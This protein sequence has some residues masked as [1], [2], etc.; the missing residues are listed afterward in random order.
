MKK[1]SCKR[2]RLERTIFR[3]ALMM[4]VLDVFLIAGYQGFYQ[5][6]ETAP[7]VRAAR[8]AESRVLAH[9]AHGVLQKPLVVEDLPQPQA[10][11]SVP[12][13]EPESP[14]SVI[15]EKLLKPALGHFNGLAVPELRR[16]RPARVVV[17]IDDMGLDPRRN[18]MAM[19][20]PGPLTL[21]FL[22]YGKNLQRA[23]A[24]AKRRGHEVLVHMPMEPLDAALDPGPE[25][26]RADMSKGLL[27]QALLDNL[28]A[29]SGYVGINNHMGSRLTQDRRA[30]G[31]VMEILQARG[32]LFVDSRTIENSVAEDMAAQYNVDHATRDVFLDHVETPEAV[33]QS[34]RKLED[35]AYRRGYA[36]AIG[37]PK[38][39]T[40]NA[41]RDWLPTLK[42][43]DLTLVPV[44]AV[45]TRPVVV[46]VS[47]S[48][49]EPPRLTAP[50]LP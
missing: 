22:P 40:L 14:G 26:L 9:D 13:T 37:H 44:S 2:K 16:V 11:P 7:A 8:P 20:L 38:D 36:V 49:Q 28:G 29:F 33:A 30:M 41:L 27:Q 1:R 48:A 24:E 19:A 34:L 32:L 50:S 18:R 6:P 21:S 46:P 4:V 39:V 5:K 12:T 45:V 10:Y 15:Q 31:W 3:A 23:A 43:K 17:I 42:E 47:A 25:A 35:V